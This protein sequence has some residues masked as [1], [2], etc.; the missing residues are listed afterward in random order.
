[1]TGTTCFI[2]GDQKPNSIETHHIVPRRYG[3]SDRDENLV[4]LCASCH[5]AIEKLYDERFYETLGVTKPSDNDTITYTRVDSW[6]DLEDDGI[7]YI[8]GNNQF[9]RVSYTECRIGRRRNRRTVVAVEMT[10]IPNAN[11]EMFYNRDSITMPAEKVESSFTQL[12]QSVEY[13]QN[14]PVYSVEVHGDLIRTLN[15]EMEQ[16][17]SESDQ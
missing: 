4:D 10:P 11:E 17:D 5:S 16:T 2:C 1:M 9:Y 13:P 7:C 8:D 12:S 15:N 14:N 3:G 6:G